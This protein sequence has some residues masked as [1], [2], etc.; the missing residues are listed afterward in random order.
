MAREKPMPDPLQSF[1]GFM[2]WV[3]LWLV[4]AYAA[5]FTLGHIVLG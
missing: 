4:V 5:A 2:A 1:T 3:F